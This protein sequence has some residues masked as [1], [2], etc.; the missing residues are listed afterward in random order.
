MK[1]M[2]D[3]F[4][5]LVEDNPDDI[6]LTQMAFRKCRIPNELVVAEDGQEA[7]DFLFVR[8][9]YADRDPGHQP[10]LILL[11]LKLPYVSGLE[12]LQ[13]IRAEPKTRLIPVVVLTSSVEEKD[14]SESCRLGANS[15]F[16][17]PL[18]FDEFTDLIQQ[19]I[20]SW[21]NGHECPAED[22]D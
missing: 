8:G 13:L 21:G 11:D 19:L 16:L 3:Q 6:A 12:V 10:S 7:L 20:T 9:K 4:I 17:K 1:K 15:F 2:D 5:L 14:Q 22:G 18:D